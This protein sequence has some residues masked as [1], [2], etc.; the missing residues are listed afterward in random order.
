[1]S[2]ISLQ[3]QGK[4]FT[5]L[6]KTSRLSCQCLVTEMR[7]KKEKSLS[8]SFVTKPF[9][10]VLRWSWVCFIWDQPTCLLGSD[11]LLLLGG[12]FTPEIRESSGASTAL[13]A[14][15]QLQLNARLIFWLPCTFDWRLAYNVIT[16]SKMTTQATDCEARAGT[17]LS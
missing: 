8:R 3:V 16:F 17:N 4:V 10:A 6:L 5:S 12:M 11:C 2:L 13:G 7:S 1:M 15:R 9:G 14:V